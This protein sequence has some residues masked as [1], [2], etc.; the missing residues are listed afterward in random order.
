[1]GA[2]VGKSNQTKYCIYVKAK[3][4]EKDTPNLFDFETDQIIKRNF[5]LKEKDQVV[6]YDQELIPLSQSEQIKNQVQ[7]FD[8]RMENGSYSLKAFNSSPD[9]TLWRV[10]RDE[11][12]TF[13]QPT[14]NVKKGDTIK[15]GRILLKIEDFSHTGNLSQNQD[16]L[17]KEDDDAEQGI[18][19]T[20]Q[21]QNMDDRQFQ[22]K[23]CLAETATT[24]N[25][26]LS[27][28]GCQGSLKYCHLACLKQWVSSL[29]KTK[30]MGNTKVFV[31]KKLICE[32]CKCEYKTSFKYQNFEYNLL[33]LKKSSNPYV[34]LRQINPNSKDHYF[35]MVD[36][37]NN[38]SCEIGRI[39]DCHIRLNDISVSRNHASLTLQGDKLVLKDNKS[40]FGTLVQINDKLDLQ[41]L[42]D[43]KIVLQTGKAILVLEVVKK[44]SIK[45]EQIS[46]IPA[47]IEI[48]RVINEHNYL[49]GQIQKYQQD[50]NEEKDV[51]EE[52]EN[53][54][55]II[56]DMV[57]NQQ[58]QQDIYSIGKEKKF[59][60]QIFNQYNNNNNNNSLPQAQFQSFTYH[61]NS[62]N[63]NIE[64]QNNQ[65]QPRQIGIT[66]I[67][68]DY[69]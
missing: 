68:I 45:S 33:E 46:P 2:C 9:F 17:K 4:W 21:S 6:A 7:I 60:N 14:W 23:I 3:I 1:M 59:K 11:P 31:Y 39:F 40:K 44:S 35:Y 53:N 37:V 63:I 27:A 13:N 69:E 10:I 49:S 41:N 66:D 67:R 54:D 52:I 25:P 64:N 20:D 57:D 15:L 48:C 65:Q 12:S 61:Q 5:V 30:M 43:K 62:Q 47:H 55:V 29:G 8:I 19:A 36:L 28:C 58:L 38:S 16:L 26:L 22:C 34:V 18:K 50:K 24:E 51:A 56:Y 32:L 42:K